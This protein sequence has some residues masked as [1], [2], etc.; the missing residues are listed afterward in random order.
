MKTSL[1]AFFFVTFFNF[2]MKNLEVKNLPKTAK[3]V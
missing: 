3:S 1:G 2:F